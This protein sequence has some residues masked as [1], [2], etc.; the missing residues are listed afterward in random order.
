MKIAFLISAY[1]DPAH[2]KRFIDSLP[3]ESHFFIH[4]DKGA[5]EAPFRQ[6]MTQP[7][8]HFIDNRVRVMWGSYTQ[9]QFQGSPDAGG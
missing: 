2:L 7:H 5:D 4:V 1:T 3:E 8:V 9:V 6:L